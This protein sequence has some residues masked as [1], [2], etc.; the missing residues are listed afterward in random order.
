MSTTGP[1]VEDELRR[2][3]VQRLRAKAAFRKHLM[4]YLSVNTFL[5][6]TWAFTGTGLFWPIFPIIG[7]GI[8]VAVNAWEAYGPYEVTEER[9][10]RE[11]DR[12]RGG[13]QER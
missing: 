8:G 7:W 12:M 9:I 5:V 10:R 1:D 2:Q 13:A 4:A 3:A 11:M 6:V